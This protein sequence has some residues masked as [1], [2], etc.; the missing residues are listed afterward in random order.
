MYYY[1]LELGGKQDTGAKDANGNIIYGKAVAVGALPNATTKNTAH[2][3]TN[4]N[5]AAGAYS[6]LIHAISSN[7]TLNVPYDGHITLTWS[8]SATNFTVTAATNLSAYASSSVVILFTETD[9]EAS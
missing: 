6:G 9:D 1:N 8:I 5:V 2:G 3:V 7:G 4:L